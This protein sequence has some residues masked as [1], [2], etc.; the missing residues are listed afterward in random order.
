MKYAT[1]PETSEL[2][3]LSVETLREW[4]NRRALIP[5]DIPPRSKGSP[6]QYTWQTV[7]ILRLAVSLRNRFHLELQAHKTLFAELKEFFRISKPS[8]L[9]ESTLV[10]FGDGRWK[11]V[12][13][14]ERKQVE[15][16]ALLIRLKTY[17][18]PL[19]AAFGLAD[20]SPF[21]QI[22]L[23]STEAFAAKRKYPARAEGHELSREVVA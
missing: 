7:L 22:E 18:E 5:A 1:T 8:D 17:L 11:L 12:D 23:F 13:D 9:K 10:L 15:E 4:T 3:G 6:A 16:E 19:W 21:L 2:T 20:D 14:M